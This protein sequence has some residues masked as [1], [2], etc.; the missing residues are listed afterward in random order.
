LIS[1]VLLT[2]LHAFAWAQ[3]KSGSW[4]DIAKPASWNTPGAVVPAA[5]TVEGTV[6]PRCRMSARTAQW[7]EDRR[8]RDRGWDLVG[9]YQ[10]GWDRLVIRGTAGYDGMCRPRQFQDFVFVRGTFAGTLSPQPMESR[11]DGALKRV[12][13]QSATR[14]TAEYARYA[15]TDAL[16]CPSRTTTVVFEIV[17]DGPVVR[18]LSVST[19]KR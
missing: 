11:A 8:V 17:T 16:C 12:F 15:A 9:A 4:L 3:G 7:A 6:E 18:P 19:S 10:G 14:V 1:F 5:P 2:C 13:L